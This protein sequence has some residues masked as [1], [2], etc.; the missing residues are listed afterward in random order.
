[1][2]IKKIINKIESLHLQHNLSNIIGKRGDKVSVIYCDL[3]PG[4]TK[5]RRLG[6]VCLG[7]KRKGLNSK[8]CML[9]T[10][11]SMKVKQTL[12]IHNPTFVDLKF[13]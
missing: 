5:I 9:S 6:G 12:F 13:H 4:S 11:K 3:E 7:F 2:K 1:M 8:L 10:L